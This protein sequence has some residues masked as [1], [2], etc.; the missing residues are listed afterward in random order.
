MSR[1]TLERANVVVA[2]ALEKGREMNL[3]P[4]TVAVLDDGGNLKSFAREDGP[5]A[6]LRP[7]IAI[8]KAFGAVGMG[9]SSRALNERVLERPHFGVAL[10]GASGGRL[11]PVPGGVLIKD[12]D[13]I[14]GAV[15]ISG[16]T[17]DND[18]AAAIAGIEAAGLN[19]GA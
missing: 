9:L 16:D 7:Q 2:K 13:E 4:L 10:V 17:S 3:K 8:G 11:V 14:V 18:E 19:F 15:G 6:A 5:G 1:L 12:G